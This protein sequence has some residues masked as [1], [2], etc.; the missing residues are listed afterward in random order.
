MKITI[1]ENDTTILDNRGQ[2]IM[3]ENELTKKEDVEK[4]LDEALKREYSIQEAK[5]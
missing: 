1:D 2:I 5:N 4:Q 3:L